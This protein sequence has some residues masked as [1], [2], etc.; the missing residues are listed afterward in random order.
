METGEN[1]KFSLDPPQNKTLAIKTIL[2]IDIHY[3]FEVSFEHFVNTP[4]N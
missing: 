2:T 1:E 4:K 3:T